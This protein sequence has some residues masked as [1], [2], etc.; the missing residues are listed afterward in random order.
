MLEKSAFAAL[1]TLLLLSGCSGQTSSPK[2]TIRLAVT[3][4]TY[5]T[6]IAEHLSEEFAKQRVA[7][8]DVVAAGTG[9]VLELGRNG[10][11]DV[12]LVHSRKDEDQFIK[13]GHGKRREDVMYNTFFLLGPADDPAKVKGKK[14]SQALRTIGEKKVAF[15]S[16]GDNS[17]THKREQRLWKLAGG[18][19]QWGKYD[20]TGNGMGQT[21][22]VA[23]Q[24]R[25]YVICDSGTFYSR[26]DQI[27]LVPLIDSDEELQNPYGV[28]LVNRKSAS[29][30]QQKLAE[31]LVD[32][33]ISKEGQTLI[34][35][36][37]KNGQQLFFPLQLDKNKTAQ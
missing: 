19:P 21:L 8:I 28:L 15:I 31:E 18:R 6:G 34:K 35:A 9:K 11:I 3:T 29:A 23:N 7:H 30:E 27:Q 36:F 17:G 25:A 37:R 10:D 12:A 5:D 33:L 16:R 22:D 2:V 26:S 20:E 1:V 4:S 14:P 13:A 32:F 24:R